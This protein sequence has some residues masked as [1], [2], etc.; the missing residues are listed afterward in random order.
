MVKINEEQRAESGHLVERGAEKPWPL[1]DGFT[2]TRTEDQREVFKIP[3]RE[4]S[5]MSW[6]NS[7]ASALC[8]RAHKS[9]AFAGLA[10]HLLPCSLK[11]CTPCS[12]IK[13]L[14]LFYSG[15][16]HLKGQFDFCCCWLSDAHKFVVLKKGYLW[17]CSRKILRKSFSL[18]N[19]VRKLL[20]MF[21]F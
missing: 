13:D 11:K 3:L 2:E 14:L 15:T 21:F 1:R 6:S 17:N 12:S 18:K 20:K 9:P 5:L 8:I 19:I 16:L 4:A 10:N 7:T